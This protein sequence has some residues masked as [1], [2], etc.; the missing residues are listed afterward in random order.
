MEM[1]LQMECG[2]LT[3]K[4]SSLF[5]LRSINNTVMDGRSLIT[6]PYS[7]NG[8]RNKKTPKNR[9]AYFR[10]L[11][12]NFDTFSSSSSSFSVSISGKW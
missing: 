11:L 8:L 3:E 4:R 10:S 9:K 1:C 7:A 2:G 12:W 5:S 6:A